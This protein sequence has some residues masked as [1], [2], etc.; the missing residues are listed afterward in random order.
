MAGLG[1]PSRIPR[2]AGG[3]GRTLTAPACPGKRLQPPGSAGDGQDEPG[4]SSG[5]CA[6]LQHLRVLGEAPGLEGRRDGIP[7]GGMAFPAEGWH[8]RD[9]P[10]P[11]QPAAAGH[12]HLATG[13]Q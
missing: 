10:G 6:H 13:K 3:Q 11:A 1:S 4:L 9:T 5:P 12:C 8:P 2:G 7:S